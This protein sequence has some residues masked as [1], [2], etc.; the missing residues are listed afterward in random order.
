MGSW[1]SDVIEINNKPIQTYPMQSVAPTVAVVLS[2]PSPA[3]AEAGYIE[4][5]NILKELKGLPY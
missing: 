1:K 4:K 2:I 5:Q 3:S